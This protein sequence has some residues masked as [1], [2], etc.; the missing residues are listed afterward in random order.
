LGALRNNTTG[1]NNVSLGYEAGYGITG[2]NTI[3]IGY[4]S[5]YTGAID[6]SI[7]LNASGSILNAGASGFYVDPIN[8][9]LLGSTGNV[10][11]YYADTKQIVYNSSKTFIIDHPNDS[12]K[13]LIHG[14]LE[15][16]ENGVY[17]R[18]KATIEHEGFIEINLPDYVKDFANNLTVQ[19][20]PIGNKKRIHDH[21]V[22][23]IENN[24]FTIYGSNGSYHW[25]VHGMRSSINVEPNKKD[26]LVQ[27]NGPYKWYDIN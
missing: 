19:V 27:G 12:S 3:A 14:C 13:Y 15:G 5:G 26:I 25:L 8:T 1:S 23:E 10:L 9:N 18:G 6:N 17:Y 7:I 2:S 16:P 20:T 24:K 22:S 21:M 11:T 4:R